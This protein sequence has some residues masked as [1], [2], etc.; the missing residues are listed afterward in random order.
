MPQ[1]KILLQNADSVE[2]FGIKL[3]SDVSGGK[4]QSV[5]D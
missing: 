1:K 2:N 3:N 5:C 4:K